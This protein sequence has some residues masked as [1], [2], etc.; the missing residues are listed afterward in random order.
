MIAAGN[1]I[2]SEYEKGNTVT[3]MSE[4]NVVVCR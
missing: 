1:D 3:C 4:W 2:F